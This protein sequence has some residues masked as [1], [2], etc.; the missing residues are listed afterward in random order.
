MTGS[1]SF[2]VL[3]GVSAGTAQTIWWGSL[4]IFLVVLLVVAALLQL[5]VNSAGRILGGVADIWTVG[6]QIANNTVQIPTLLRINQVATGIVGAAGDIHGALGRI[7]AHAESCSGC[8]A[9]LLSGGE[10][11]G[12]G[13]ADAGDVGG[14]A[15]GGSGGGR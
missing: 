10:S 5:I 4:G 7:H 8:P 15:P 3:A 14:T 11:P 12:A 2:G 13:G 6:K 9:C 1:V